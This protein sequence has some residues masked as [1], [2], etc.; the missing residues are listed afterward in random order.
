MQTWNESERKGS[1]NLWNSHP[2]NVGSIGHGHISSSNP[3]NRCIQILKAVL[4]N[5]HAAKETNFSPLQ[6]AETIKT[7]RT[8]RGG[9]A[10]H[11]SAPTPCCGKPSSTVTNLLVFLTDALIAALSSGLIER[12]LIT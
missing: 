2:L 4:Y 8:E 10:D 7:E 6:G 9:E 1:M 5:S 11:I 3:L 12:R